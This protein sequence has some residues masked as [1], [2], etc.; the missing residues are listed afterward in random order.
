MNPRIAIDR[1][2]VSAFCRRPHIT[3]LALLCSVLRDDFGPDSDVDV[4]VEFQA[5]YVPG[6]SFV[7]IEREFS[8]L[9]HGRRVD[10]VTPK[11]LNPRIREHV[12]DSAEP[13]YVAA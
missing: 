6:L 1:D 8:G 5:G 9:L 2:A 7:S 10:M 12:L 3:R 11:F 4:L 13:L